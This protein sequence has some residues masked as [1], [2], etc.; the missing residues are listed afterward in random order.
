MLGLSSIWM[1]LASIII[2]CVMLLGVGVLFVRATNIERRWV[3]AVSTLLFGGFSLYLLANDFPLNGR[4]IMTSIA[5]VTISLLG[6]FI[7]RAI[8]TSL[9][10]REAEAMR[11]DPATYYADLAD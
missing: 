11:P 7:G 8:D 10:E 6:F 9:G 5:A 1:N 4:D 3:V 2:A